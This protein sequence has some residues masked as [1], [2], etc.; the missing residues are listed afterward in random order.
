MPVLPSEINARIQWFEQR[1]P[2]WGDNAATIGLTVAQVASLTALV[3]AA[4]NNWNAAQAARTASKDA[5]VN[6]SSAV[7]SMTE[8]GGDLV[9]TIRAYAQTTNNNNVYSL[10]SVPPPAPPTPAGPPQPP[11]DLTADPNAD[12]TISLKW[13]GSLARQTFYTVWRRVGTSGGFTQIGSLA[14]KKF[15]DGAVPEPAGPN[16]ATQLFYQVKAQREAQVSAPSDTAMVQFG[17]G[18]GDNAQAGGLA[19][20]A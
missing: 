19:L 8:L 20:A 14:G 15:I 10:A 11:T 13:K 16:A 9:K 18:G 6:Q 1:I 3:T 12:G 17:V 7:G 5:T 4:R 2:Q